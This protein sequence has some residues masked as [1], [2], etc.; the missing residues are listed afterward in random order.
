[1]KK[2]KKIQNGELPE[3]E[4]K[5]RVEEA[6]QSMGIRHLLEKSPFELSGGQQRRVALCVV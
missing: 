4:I 3:E 5:A 1:M 2:K 6:A